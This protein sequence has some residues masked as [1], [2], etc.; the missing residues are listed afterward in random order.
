MNSRPAVVGRIRT[1]LLVNALVDPDEAAPRL[2]AG[3]RPHVTARGTVVGCCLLQ[4]EQ[5]RP[6]GC[7]P[8]LGIG[9][10][11]A[12]HRISVEWDDAVGE[13][14]VGVYVP[15]RLT[16]SRLAVVAGGRWFPGVHRSAEVEVRRFTGELTWSV[17]ADGDAIAVRTISMD[18][19]GPASDD[20]V[21]GATCLGAD[22]GFSPNRRGMLEGVQMRP[23]HRDAQRV[24]TD[25][26]TSTFLASFRTAVPAPAYLMESVGVTWT[27]YPRTLVPQIATAAPR[28]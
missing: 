1:R 27:P 23:D 8:W 14:A 24:V 15:E 20:Q 5:V 13:R 18:R 22:V 26:C 11:A 3:L 10:R 7:P 6:A 16:D 21:V 4:L 19:S 25:A 2:P 28:V 9:L 12:A 17:V